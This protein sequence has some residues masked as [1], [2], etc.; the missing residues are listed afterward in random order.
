MD[1]EKE[2]IPDEQEDFDTD[3]DTEEIT[4]IKSLR[5]D[6]PP[7]YFTNIDGKYC[8][9]VAGR[10]E[11]DELK[12]LVDDV[13][14]QPLEDGYSN[15]WFELTNDTL[16]PWL[17]FRAKT[18]DA[19]IDWG[20]GSGEVALDTLTPTHTYSKAGKYVVK[21][22]GVTEIGIQYSV[23]FTKY[24]RCL[25]AIELNNEVTTISSSAFFMAVNLKNASVKYITSIG[26]S[27]F[28]YCSA[29]SYIILPNN[30]ATTENSVFQFD[31]SISGIEL[32]SNLESVAGTIFYY[33]R[34]LQTITIPASVTSIGNSAFGYCSSLTE[35]HCLGTVPPTLGTSSFGNLPTNWIAYVP[36]GYGD[37]YR[38]A[39]SNYYE[40]ILEEGQTPNRM[41]LAKFN[42]TK[43]EETDEPQDDMR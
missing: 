27:A 15:F 2:Y 14:W 1:F 36:V 26:S 39:W 42:S 34:L 23:P 40:H 35:V 43:T 22:K 18:D 7:Q 12:A 33:C 8:K 10:E 37:T 25:S 20:D 19:V 41:M 3:F 9:D 28:A 4:P 24:C 5:S 16:S 38:A 6:P 11:L 32:P 17:K 13:P 29:L 21:V 31:F 30:L